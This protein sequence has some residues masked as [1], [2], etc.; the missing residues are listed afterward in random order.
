MNFLPSD[1]SL[2]E[3]L[4]PLNVKSRIFEHKVDTSKI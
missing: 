1:Y 4:E 2:I 3:K